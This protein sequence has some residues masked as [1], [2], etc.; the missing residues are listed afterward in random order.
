LADEIKEWELAAGTPAEALKNLTRDTIPGPPAA[1][2]MTA[3][4]S[5]NPLPLTN[6]EQKS[7]NWCGPATARNII[8]WNSN[9]FHGGLKT[10]WNGDDLSQEVL[11]S[12]DWLNTVYDNETDFNVWAYPLNCW[13]DNYSDCETDGHY[14]QEWSPSSQ[15][16]NADLKYDVDLYYPLVLNVQWDA[17]DPQRLW[18]YGSGAMQHYITGNGYHY[19]GYKESTTYYTHYMDTYRTSSGGR[20]SLGQQ[21]DFPSSN[22]VHLLNNMGYW[23]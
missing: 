17:G 7:V 9:E 15:F 3:M 1:N 4:S 12:S 6:E 16:Y 11:A 14:W 5:T 21:I 23:W 13:W 2:A 20:S 10:S 19:V 18:G 8:Y 22:M